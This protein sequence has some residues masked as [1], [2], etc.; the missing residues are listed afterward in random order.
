MGHSSTSVAREIY[1]AVIPRL[2][3]EAATALD[4]LIGELDSSERDQFGDQ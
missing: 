1:R 3:K 2:R 4:T